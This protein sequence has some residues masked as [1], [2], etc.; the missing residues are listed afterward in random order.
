MTSTKADIPSPSSPS[1]LTDTVLRLGLL[2]LLVFACARIVAPFVAVL[3]W[4]VVLAVML[5]PLHVRLSRRL[6]N[7]WSAVLIG[8]AGIAFLLVPTILAA[9]SLASS[10]Q[11][12]IEGLR[13]H[14]LTVPPPPPRLA[15][16]PVVGDKLSDAW[17]LVA[18]NTPAAMAKYGKQLSGLAGWLAGFVGKLAAG[19][20]AFILSLGIAA[21]LVAYAKSCAALARQLF[22]FVTGYQGQG[23]RLV[24]LTT[25]T[26]RGV[27]VGVVGVAA[28]QSAL[29]G[30]GFFMIGLPAAGLLIL[31]VFL[32]GVV[33]IPATLLT[34]PVIA[35]VL[36]TRDTGPAAIFAV[37]TLVAGLSD[38]FLKPLML[39]RG[40][41]VP[42]PVILIGVIGGMVVDGLLGLFVGP[43]ILAVGYVLFLEWLRAHPD[44][45]AAADETPSP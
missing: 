13:N 10:A 1:T 11:W 12:L 43:V 29:L 35:Y 38:N 45:S 21:V 17:A 2:A 23:A 39:G 19:E 3:L 25:A 42:M 26:I 34:L 14:T 41:E 32:L 44:T 28:I 15:G 40:L 22:E 7:K 8:I 30:V 36:A 6:G 31:V 5:Y 33:Q 27:A 4:S 16:L 37:W 20:L 9:A 18:T 24:G